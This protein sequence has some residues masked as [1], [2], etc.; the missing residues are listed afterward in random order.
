MGI[1]N[2]FSGKNK[3]D[4]K[5]LSLSLPMEEPTMVVKDMKNVEAD[6]ESKATEISPLTVSYAT[7]WPIDVIYGYLHKNYEEKGFNDAMVNSNLAFRDLNRNIIRNKILMVFREVNLNYDVMRQEMQTNIDI[8]GAAGLLA[9][10]ANIEKSL[11]LVESHKEE[12]RRLEQDFRNNA[13]EASV[14]LQ[15]YEC[16]FLRGISTIAMGGV[17][18]KR[19][20]AAAV[21]M[22]SAQQATA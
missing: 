9:D 20:G 19:P 12:L 13:N 6:M 16:G 18:G 15:S 2:I 17:N 8:C 10:V 7:G 22:A 14:P 3:D 4:S 11:S 21:P 5:A 1:F